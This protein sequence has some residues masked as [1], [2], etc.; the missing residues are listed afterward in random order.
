M[1][2]ITIRI[3]GEIFHG[4]ISQIRKGHG[5]GTK[6]RYFQEVLWQPTKQQPFRIPACFVLTILMG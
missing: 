4:L 6:T 3:F 2:F 5:W 1:E